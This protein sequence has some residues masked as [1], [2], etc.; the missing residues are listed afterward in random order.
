MP[1]SCLTPEQVAEHLQVLP[2]TVRKWLR[3]GQLP[4]VK[5]GR[6]W[7]VAESTIDGLIKGEVRFGSGSELDTTTEDRNR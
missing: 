1:D 7:R 4:G 6:Q 2:K 3:D 5:L